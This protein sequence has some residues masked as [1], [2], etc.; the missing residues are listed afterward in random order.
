VF[1][2]SLL[3]DDLPRRIVS[4]SELAWLPKFFVGHLG[5]STFVAPLVTVG[6]IYAVRDK[7]PTVQDKDGHAG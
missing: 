6:W 1:R 4:D 7:V 2:E 3:L 5:D